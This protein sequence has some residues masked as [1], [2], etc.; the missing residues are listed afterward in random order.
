MIAGSIL[1]FIPSAGEFVI[2][3]LLGGSRTV[4]MGNLIQQQF[5]RPATGLRERALG[6]A[7]R[8]AARGHNVLHPQ[9]RARTSWR[10]CRPW[11]SRGGPVYKGLGKIPTGRCSCSRA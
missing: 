8:S 1:V 3:N 11:E 2:P 7:R 10:G 6:D 9:G 5:L 4:L